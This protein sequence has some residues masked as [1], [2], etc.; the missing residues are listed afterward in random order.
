MGRGRTIRELIKTMPEHCFWVNNGPIID[1]LKELRDA[2]RD[3]I[4]DEQYNH[5][6]TPEKNDFA[7]WILNSLG[8]SHC[9]TEVRAAKKQKTAASRINECLKRY[10]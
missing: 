8:D 5:H 2:L 3:E 1:D 7:D 9:A 6:V 4:T 10:K